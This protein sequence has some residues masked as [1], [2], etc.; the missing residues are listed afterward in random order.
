M[1]TTFTIF[2]IHELQTANCKRIH[3]YF[4]SNG[5]QRKLRHHQN[6]VPILHILL[7]SLLLLLLWITTS[8]YKPILHSSTPHIIQMK[9]KTTL[10][11]TGYAYKHNMQ[12]M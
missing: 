5:T 9:I 4:D 8:Y 12:C 7:P 3:E 1:F 2:K 11:F 10:Y 6:V